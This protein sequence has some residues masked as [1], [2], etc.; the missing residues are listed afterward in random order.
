[1]AE[2]AVQPPT[3]L[4]P[5]PPQ[6][7][8][9]LSS[10]P[11][12]VL[13][14]FS[15]LLKNQMLQN[16][17]K[18]RAAVGQATQGALSPDGRFDQQQ[19][20]ASIRNNPDAGWASLEAL[21]HG[22]NLTNTQIDTLNRQREIISSVLGALPT[23]NLTKEHL[24]NAYTTMVRMGIPSV[25]AVGSLGRIT[26][27]PNMAQQI[28]IERGVGMTPAQQGEMVEVVDPTTGDKRYV[29]K[30]EAQQYPGLQTQLSGDQ[31]KSIESFGRSKE[32]TGQFSQRALPLQEAVRNIDALVTKYG[33]GVFGPGAERRKEWEGFLQTLSP[34][35]AKKIGIDPQD[36]EYF[37][38]TKKY[39]TQAM[40]NRNVQLG[41]HSDQQLA[42]TIS[43]FPNVEVTDLALP[44]LAKTALAAQRAEQAQMLEGQRSGGP[45]YTESL[46]KWPQRNDVRAF[47]LDLMPQAQR[48]KLIASLT[49]DE[50]KR[51]NNSLRS[52]YDAGVIDRSGAPSP[53]SSAPSRAPAAPVAAKTPPKPAVP[54]VRL[55][56]RADGTPGWFIS[57]PARPGK[58]LEVTLPGLGQ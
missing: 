27:S 58:H 38:K 44:D 34:G 26:N 22:Q 53:S 46:S 33:Q 37:A 8:G 17:L 28:G 7:Q 14:L 41:G 36:L 31:Q 2:L 57:D 18:G 40:S 56:R 20:N 52:A 54:G 25:D 30:A 35:A 12:Q 15:G 10:N 47:A 1:V 24:Y 16:E 21:Q 9:G 49:P 6:Q 19:F 11:A 45:K 3:G 51:F 4:Y 55:G 32:Y 42:T 29:S 13:D 39:L 23:K 50:K 5:Q 43:G 48:D